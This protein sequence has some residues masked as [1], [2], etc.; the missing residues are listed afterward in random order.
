MYVAFSWVIWRTRNKMAIEKF[1][2]AP[3]EVVFYATSF[4]QKW[5]ILLKEDEREKLEQAR[6]QVLR[7][8]HNFQPRQC[9]ENLLDLK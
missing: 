3:T 4:L 7:W 1:P 2:N 6:S 5:K 8:I 9:N